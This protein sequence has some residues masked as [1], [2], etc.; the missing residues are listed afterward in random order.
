MRYSS[1]AKPES[2]CWVQSLS[3]FLFPCC[4]HRCKR[5]DFPPGE[6]SFFSMADVNLL[7]LAPVSP[8]R[9][10]YGLAKQV[11]MSLLLGFLY[12]VLRSYSSDV[13]GVGTSGL[14]AV[15][16]LLPV[17]GSPVK[18]W[19]LPFIPARGDDNRRRVVKNGALLFRL[20]DGRL[21][22]LTTLLKPRATYELCSAHLEIPT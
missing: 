5:L 7:F 11:G 18:S 2:R 14:I 12:P 21:G 4:S 8:R 10:S 15:C 6:G 3:A 17:S 20:P 9:Y 16:W 19:L 1:R 22:F 13:F